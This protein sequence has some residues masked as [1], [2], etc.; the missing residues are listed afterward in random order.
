MKAFVFPGQGSQ[1]KGMG[2]ELFDLFPEITGKA[3]EILG[4]SI[5]ELCLE[6]SRNVLNV[7]QY[8]QPALYTVNALTCYKEIEETGGQPDYL[9]GH[10]LGEYNALLAGGVFDFE[11]GLRLVQKRAELMSKAVGGGMA[12]II[13][14]EGEKVLEILKVKGFSTIDVANFNSPSQT[15]ISGLK[16][17]IAQAGNIFKEA[18]ARLFIPLKVSGAFHSRYMEPARREFERFLESFE[19]SSPAIPVIS[20]VEAR[21]YTRDKVKRLLAD[22]ITHSVRWTE[23]IRYLMGKGVTEFKETGPGTVLAK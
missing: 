17:D 11:T 8:T 23:S 1:K 2:E 6:D 5:K 22:Q 20:N 19:F 18:G 10:S 4:Y 7:T 16:E 15:V 9:A 13:G 21:P 12:A 14:L 3:D